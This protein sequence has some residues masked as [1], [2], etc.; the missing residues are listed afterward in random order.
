VSAPCITSEV[1][2]V[3]EVWLATPPDHPLAA[4][5]QVTIE[6]LAREPFVITRPGQWQRRLLDWLFADRNLEPRIVCEIDEPAATYMLVS[7][8]LGLSIFPQ[9]A[10]SSFPETGV[11][12]VGIDHPHC[13]RTLSLHWVSE[14]RL[15]AAARLM[16]AQIA[17]WEWD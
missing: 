7:A 9:I 15:P 11:A 12:W 17:H 2:H 6:D 3:L 8:G 14:D 4:A 16:R 5:S 10:R 13:N 1:L